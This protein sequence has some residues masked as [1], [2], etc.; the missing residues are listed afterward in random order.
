[1]ITFNI[2]FEDEMLYLPKSAIEICYLSYGNIFVGLQE[3][4]K[5]NEG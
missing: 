4:V 2:Y 3:E 1:M 5:I